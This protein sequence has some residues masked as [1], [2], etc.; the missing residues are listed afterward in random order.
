MA[1]RLLEVPLRNQTLD[2]WCWAAVASAVSAYFQPYLS[3][4]A[5]CQVAS[6]LINNSRDCCADPTRCDFRAPLEDAFRAIGLGRA[7]TVGPLLFSDITNQVIVQGFPVGARLEGSGV[8]G[9]FVLII[10][11]DD[12][13]GDVTVTDPSGAAG[14]P[15]WRGAMPYD[16]L[17]HDYGGWRGICTNS[18]LIG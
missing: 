9:H 2:L 4:M 6:N 15:S 1:S 3:F 12:A 11:C 18:V 10:G 7:H 8:A 5:P 17:L 13:T 14:L 16:K